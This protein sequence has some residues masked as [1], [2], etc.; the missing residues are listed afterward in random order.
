MLSHGHCKWW[1]HPLAQKYHS[2]DPLTLLQ[3]CRA[4]ERNIIHDAETG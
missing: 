3:M 4:D 1:T 2:I